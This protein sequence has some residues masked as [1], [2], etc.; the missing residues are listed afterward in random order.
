MAEKRASES[1]IPRRVRGERR[2]RYTW[3][4]RLRAGIYGRAPLL[5]ESLLAL[6]LIALVVL[7]DAGYFL[8]VRDAGNI[9]QALLDTLSLLTLNPAVR[10]GPDDSF[11]AALVVFNLLFSVLFVQSVLNSARALFT[12]RPEEA[13]QLGRAAALRD[14]VI[15]C[16]LGRIGM[17]VVTRLVEAGYQAAVVE[18]DWGAEFV[19]RALE[20]R[21]PVV[22]GDAREAAALRRAGL[23]RACAVIAGID[24]D[25]VN[26]EIAL[27][28]RAERPSVRVI[29]RAFS[30]DF[31][32]GLER[33]FGRDTAFSASALAAPSFA[34]ATVA[35]EIEHVL[36]LDGALLGVARVA[37]RAADA[38][39]TGLRALE[40]RYDVRFVPE[41]LRAGYATVMGRLS[42]LEALRLAGAT[43]DGVRALPTPFQPGE[44]HDTVIVCGLGKV[45]Y[46]VVGLLH[47]Q[48]PRPRIVVLYHERD[49]DEP[50]LRRVRGLAAVEARRGDA[51]DGETLRDAGL[52]RAFAVA[53][54]TSDD[55][56]NVRIGLE[57]R[58]QR[59][60]LHVVL[61]VFSDTLAERLVDLFGIHT[62]YSV[63]D[64][65]S[66]TLAAAAVL[67]GVGHAFFADDRLYAMNELAARAGD[68]L[69]GRNVEAI[70][71]ETGAVVIGLRRGA[72]PLLVLPPADTVVAPGDAVTLAARLDALARLRS[73][74]GS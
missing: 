57:A 23:R 8:S 49:E 17:R 58:R 48:R 41:P 26:V 42:S 67:G 20:M 13:R 27:A 12:R 4:Q 25:L 30:E 31:D 73:T 54:L 16:G 37:L 10:P 47:A 53:A 32:R 72:G 38:T 62:A 55:L 15:I 70:R 63:S 44:R 52:E 51:R 7:T 46:R 24:G 5:V 66:P 59:A 65:A 39:P 14:H 35:R 56:T 60:D 11:G 69:S 1:S 18:R 29:L 45:G 43:G 22:T 36:P 34:A 6:A 28:A 68:R 71:G 40:A 3:W 50:F 33:G 21:V 64:L 61:R 2:Q 74:R 9:G 19:P